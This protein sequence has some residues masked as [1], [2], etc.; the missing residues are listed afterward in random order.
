MKIIHVKL[1][2]SQTTEYEISSVILQ[3]VKKE[4]YYQNRGRVLILPYQ[5]IKRKIS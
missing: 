1:M 3:T 2:K 5:G 4:G